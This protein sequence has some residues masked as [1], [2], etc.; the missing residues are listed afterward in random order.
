MSKKNQFFIDMWSKQVKK[1]NLN[2]ELIIVEWNPELNN[3]LLKDKLNIPK[4]NENQIIRIIT[5]SEND[6]KQ[7]ENSHKLKMFQMIAKNVGIKRSNGKFILATNIDII[8]SDNFFEFLSKKNLKENAIFRCDR[9]D[10]N[11]EE[12][13]ALNF[14]EKKILKNC[15]MINKKYYSINTKTNKKDYVQICI[16]SLLYSIFKGYKNKFSF[17]RKFLDYRK[18]TFK[19]IIIKII[20][21]IFHLIRMLKYF[22]DMLIIAIFK[23]KIHTNACGDFT[24]ACRKTWFDLNGYYEFEGY[25]WHLDTIFLHKALSNKKKFIE[26][27]YKIYHIN[28]TDVASGYIPGEKHLFNKLITNKIKY[29]DDNFLISSTT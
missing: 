28:Q 8:F 15:T 24:L 20:I 21:G 16:Q 12:F 13:D 3:S 7:F 23:K 25:S 11:Y 6:H 5:V 10:I 4:L 9:Y 22:L 1:Y 27:N 26:L 18:K 14:N 19:E 2:C 17:I 29:I